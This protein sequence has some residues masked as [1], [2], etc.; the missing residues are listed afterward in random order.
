MF[1][2]KYWYRC[3][4]T[5]IEVN[6]VFHARVVLAKLKATGAIVLKRADDEINN[7]K[8]FHYLTLK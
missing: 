8:W 2:L 4:V 3:K 6:D 7:G 1:R 5:E